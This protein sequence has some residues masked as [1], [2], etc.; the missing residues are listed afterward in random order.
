MYTLQAP[1]GSRIE[2]QAPCILGGSLTRTLQVPGSK[3]PAIEKPGI[4]PS[5][6]KA[7]VG[8]VPVLGLFFLPLW[9]RKGQFS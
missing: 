1:A 4:T 9:K 2:V 7:A 8:I 6:T 5:T 3:D